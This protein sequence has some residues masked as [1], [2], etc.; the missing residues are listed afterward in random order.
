MQRVFLYLKELNG[1]RTTLVREGMS[2]YE[3]RVIGM[4]LQSDGTRM[5]ERTTVLNT[6]EYAECGQVYSFIHF[7]ITTSHYQL[8]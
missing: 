8:T 4:T 1:S 6:S 3:D 2:V 5:L 7:L